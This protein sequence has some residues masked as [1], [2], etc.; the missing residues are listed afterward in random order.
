MH[1][2]FNL[3][4]T[5]YVEFVKTDGN[6]N[7]KKFNEI[8]PVIKVHLAGNGIRKV[9]NGKSL[10]NAPVNK[11]PGAYDENNLINGKRFDCRFIFG[12]NTFTYYHF[13]ECFKQYF[14]I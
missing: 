11:Q 10:N 7:P 14:K 1:I 2:D 5:A 12:I 3:V 9:I 8:H 4:N 6:Y 13:S